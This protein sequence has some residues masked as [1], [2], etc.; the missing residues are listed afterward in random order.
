MINR[1]RTGA[2]R[3]EAK[4]PER[5][6]IETPR[7]EETRSRE[8]GTETQRGGKDPERWKQRWGWGG[9][10]VWKQRWQRLASSEVRVSVRSAAVQG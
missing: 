5:E 1:E 4:N 8:R 3:Q 10:Q 9:G 6:R 2:Q 7:L